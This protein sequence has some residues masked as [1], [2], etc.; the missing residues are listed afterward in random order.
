MLGLFSKNKTTSSE[1]SQPKS[2]GLFEKFKD[3]LSK[4]K[5][6][7]SSVLGEL[8]EV[9]RIIDLRLLE[10]IE[11]KLILADLGVETTLFLLEPFKDKIIKGDPITSKEFKKELKISMLNLLKDYHYPF[12]PQKKPCALFFLGVNGVG[13]TTTIAKLADKYKKEGY[14]LLM[15][16]GDTFRAAAIDQLKTWGERLNVPVIAQREGAD[17]SAVI[18]QGLEYALKEKIDLT[19]IDTA[20]RLHTKYNLIEELKKMHRVMDKLLNKE[21]RVNILVI[22]AT[23]GQNSLSQVEHFSKAIPIDALII[24]KM[25]G[26]AKGGIALSIA[27]KF[28]LPIL[29]IGL[30]E[31]PEDLVPFDK[32]AFVNAIFPD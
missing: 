21:A 23:T 22:D 10:E 30:G 27:H 1:S 32:E 29:F 7:F 9:D 15:I 12:P 4:T 19:L 6:K 8:F 28:K 24:T 11:E 17:P 31:K 3:G 18:Y 26:T 2:K 20:G 14:S 25:D 13:K 5:E 16:A